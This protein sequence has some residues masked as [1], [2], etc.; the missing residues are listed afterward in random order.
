MKTVQTTIHHLFDRFEHLP[1]LVRWLSILAITG[2]IGLF[3][4]LKVLQTVVS[5]CKHALRMSDTTARLG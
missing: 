1:G 3:D 2:I 4:Y 5:T